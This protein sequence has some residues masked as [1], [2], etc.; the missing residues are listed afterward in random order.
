MKLPVSPDKGV[1]VS[2]FDGS[3]L[4]I[5]HYSVYGLNSAKFAFP[6]SYLVQLCG[7]KKVCVIMCIVRTFRDRWATQGRAAMKIEGTT[8]LFSFRKENLG[9][10]VDKS[11]FASSMGAQ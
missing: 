1:F 4:L 11:G 3:F 5:T 10:S 6:P 2:S 8:V 7:A 9:L